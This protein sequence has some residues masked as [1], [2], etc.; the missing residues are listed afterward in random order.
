MKVAIATEGNLV[1]AHFG[2]CGEYTIIEIDG[3]RVINQEVLKN[4]GYECGDIPNLLGE[5]GVKVIVAGGMGAGALQ[6]FSLVGIQPILGIQGNIPAVIDGL[7]KGT[8]EG[9]ESLCQGEGHGHGEN[10]QCRR[11]Q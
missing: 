2:R 10:H 8:I 11:G 1:S 9:G 7:I 4:T 5:K 6:K 3:D